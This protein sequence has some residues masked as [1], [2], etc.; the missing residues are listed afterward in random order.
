MQRRIANVLLGYD[1][2]IEVNRRRIAV[3]EEMVRVSSRNGSSIFAFP[4]TKAKHQ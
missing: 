1:D 4:G 3:L 2:L